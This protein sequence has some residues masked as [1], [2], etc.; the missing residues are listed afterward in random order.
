MGY[1]RQFSDEGDEFGAFF[2]LI[3]FAMILAFIGFFITRNPPKEPPPSALQG[4]FASPDAPA[5]RFDGSKLAF[6]GGSP[7]PMRYALTLG[8]DGI[9]IEPSEPLRLGQDTD[10]RWTFRT[11]V[12]AWSYRIRLAHVIEGKAYGVTN[13]SDAD[14]IEFATADGTLRAFRPASAASCNDF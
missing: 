5:I 4:C 8:K 11:P 1:G 14:Y 13:I 10:G 7:P 12:E 3:P 2:A 6:A 9:H